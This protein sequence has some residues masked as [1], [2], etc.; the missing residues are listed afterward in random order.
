MKR[1]K[2]ATSRNYAKPIYAAISLSGNEISD[3]QEA[4]YRAALFW[5]KIQSVA[6]KR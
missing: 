6:G 1:K 3:L 4:A 2:F 5:C